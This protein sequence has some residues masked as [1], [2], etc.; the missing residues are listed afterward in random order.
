MRILKYTVL[1]RSNYY[2]KWIEFWTDDNHGH[3]YNLSSKFGYFHE[4]LERAG[5]MDFYCENGCKGIKVTWEKI[6]IN[7]EIKHIGF[8]SC[9]N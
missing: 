8:K 6:G 3:D 4:A 1:N 2:G 5:M 7:W 9:T